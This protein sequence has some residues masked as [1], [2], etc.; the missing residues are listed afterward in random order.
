MG[1]VIGRL[2]GR[3][4]KE[5]KSVKLPGRL[6][7]KPRVAKALI[8]I[9]ESLGGEI[10]QDEDGAYVN[11]E[12]LRN[13]YSSLAN[14]ENVTV[15]D[16]T[17]YLTYNGKMWQVSKTNGL[18]SLFS[19][20]KQGSLEE[21][22]VNAM[23]NEDETMSIGTYRVDV[24]KLTAWDM[25]TGEM[26]D[27]VDAVGRGKYGRA[28]VVEA[29]RRLK[30]QGIENEDLSTL[31][32]Q[33]DN[34]DFTRE[35]AENA[36]RQGFSKETV[37][38]K[39]LET[40]RMSYDEETIR[41]MEGY[42]IRMMSKAI[43]NIVAELSESSD[44]EAR[45]AAMNR[46][47]A[48][49]KVGMARLRAEMLSLI[50]RSIE[51]MTTKDG[52]RNVVV[53]N[54]LSASRGFRNVWN[55]ELSIFSME[56]Y[57]WMK[58]N[59]AEN[60]EDMGMMDEKYRSS[61][62][63]EGEITQAKLDDARSFWMTQWRMQ[64]EDIKR[65]IE[66]LLY[67]SSEFVAKAEGME[68]KFDW[69]GDEA[70]RG[71]ANKED[72]EN[73]DDD[74]RVNRENWQ[75]NDREES[76]LDNVS[77][78]TY[79][80]LMDCKELD[81][82]YNDGR[83]KLDS[84]GEEKHVNVMQALNR[85][86]EMIEGCNTGEE[87]YETLKRNS[88]DP[89]V[90]D[91]IA[92]L[93]SS[94]E[95]A[96]AVQYD[97]KGNVKYD[98]ESILF[99]QFFHDMTKV[100]DVLAQVYLQEA[101]WVNGKKSYMLNV[102]VHRTKES[103]NG[104]LEEWITNAK[105]GVRIGDWADLNEEEYNEVWQLLKDDLKKYTNEEISENKDDIWAAVKAYYGR[106]GLDLNP[107]NSY[108]LSLEG[109][110][111][112]KQIKKAL[113]GRAYPTVD[114]EAS[115]ERNRQELLKTIEALHITRPDI[116][117]RSVSVGNKH[118]QTRT[119][120]NFFGKLQKVLS[121]DPRRCIDFLMS[122]MTSDIMFDRE[123]ETEIWDAWHGNNIGT[124]TEAKGSFGLHHTPDNVPFRQ[125]N[126]NNQQTVDNTRYWQDKAK[127]STDIYS[128]AQ[129]G[130]FRNEY[131]QD[132]YEE[133]LVAIRD[134]RQMLYGMDTI[135][136][137]QGLNQSDYKEWSE[138]EYEEV[139]MV[140]AT[141]HEYM[142]NGLQRADFAYGTCG[143]YQRMTLPSDSPHNKYV[144]MRRQRSFTSVAVKMANILEQERIRRRMV[145]ERENLDPEF[146]IGSFD[147]PKK[148]DKWMYIPRLNTMKIDFS[149]LSD[150]FSKPMTLDEALDILDN[151]EE[152]SKE[153]YRLVMS[154]AAQAA[155]MEEF[156]VYQ[157][158]MA[159]DYGFDIEGMQGCNNGHQAKTSKGSLGHRPNTDDYAL[160]KKMGKLADNVDKV[161]KGDITLHV[162]GLNEIEEKLKQEGKEPSR[163]V[164][165]AM[166]KIRE[167]MTQVKKMRLANTSYWTYERSNGHPMMVLLTQ[168][169]NLLSD[170]MW[171]SQD[172]RLNKDNGE[173]VDAWRISAETWVDAVI[174]E[175]VW[176]GVFNKGHYGE[177]VLTLFANSMY[178][179]AQLIQLTQDDIAF[180][181]DMTDFQKR[182]KQTVAPG[183][184]FN[185]DSIYGRKYE[186][187][188]VFEDIEGDMAVT[189]YAE[190]ISA[191]LDQKVTKG[192]IS[193]EIARILK[194]KYLEGDFTM[195]DGQ[196][197]RSMESMRATLDMMGKWDKATDEAFRRLANGTWTIDD[198]MKPMLIQKYYS[199][200][201]Q[202]E[203]DEQGHT[204]R[205]GIQFK[206]GNAPMMA[207][208]QSLPGVMRQNDLIA[209]IQSWMENNCIDVVE[210]KS[211]Q[212][213][214][215]KQSAIK[216]S[217]Q[218]AN[219]WYESQGQNNAET[220]KFV[221]TE[222]ELK[223][224]A[225]TGRLMSGYGVRS[226]QARIV[227]AYLEQL[228]GLNYRG[229]RTDK[230]RKEIGND[231]NAEVAKNKY[232]IS[233]KYE[234]RS[235]QTPQHEHLS[236]IEVGMGI[237][238]MKLVVEDLGD[239]AVF[240]VRD[241]NGNEKT[242]SAKEVRDLYQRLLTSKTVD[243][244]VSLRNIMVDPKKLGEALRSSIKSNKRYGA[245]MVKSFDVDENSN[246]KVPLFEL[247]NMQNIQSLINSLSR[248]R[249]MKTKL[250]GGKCIQMCCFGVEDELGIVM[251][252]GN[253]EL[254]LDDAIA[255]VL[256]ENPKMTRKRAK[257]IA[258]KRLREEYKN[259]E[260]SIA[261]YECYMPCW[262]KDLLEA[263]IK[264]T[265]NGE[266]IV[267]MASIPTE[268]REMIGYRVPTEDK[269]S[270]FPLK[271]KGFLPQNSGSVC[272][273]PSEITLIT[274][275]DF[276]IDSVYI[277]MR[278]FDINWNKA[279]VDTVSLSGDF[280][281]YEKNKRGVAATA[282]NILQ[283][284]ESF[285][286]ILAE[287]MYAANV[288]IKKSGRHRRAAKGLI[289]DVLGDAIKEGEEETIANEISKELDA[290]LIKKGLGEAKAG[291][292]MYMNPLVLHRYDYRAEV[293]TQDRKSRNNAIVDIAWSVLTN[294]DTT[295]K[296]LNP[297]GFDVMKKCQLILNAVRVGAAINY[298]QFRTMSFEEAKKWL[299]QQNADVLSRL[300]TAKC[301]LNP[302][303][304]TYYFGQNKVGGT[305]TAIAASN[306]SAHALLQGLGV[307]FNSKSYEISVNSKKL[308]EVDGTRIKSD[309]LTTDGLEYISKIIGTW[310]AAAVD[311]AKE[312]TSKTLNFTEK[313][314]KVVALMLRSGWNIEE[315]CIFVT[316]PII[317]E[318]I[319]RIS[320]NQYI[321]ETAIMRQLA[322]ETKKKASEEVAV[323][324]NNGRNESKEKKLFNRMEYDGWA[325]VT[326]DDML[327]QYDGKASAVV[328]LAVLT[329]YRRLSEVGRDLMTASSVHRTDKA[330]GKDI[331]DIL[332]YEDKMKKLYRKTFRLNVPS[333]AKLSSE[334]D[335]ELVDELMI[336]SNEY[337]VTGH[338]NRTGDREFFVIDKHSL[339]DSYQEA[340]EKSNEQD[341][342]EAS[343]E[344]MTEEDVVSNRDLE[345]E[346]ASFNDLDIESQKQYALETDKRVVQNEEGQQ[347]IY[348]EGKG[349]YVLDGIYDVDVNK[350][351]KEA[352]NKVLAPLNNVDELGRPLALPSVR[353][354]YYLGVRG[355]ELMYAQYMPFM[356][357]EFQ[358]V[359]DRVSKLTSVRTMDA[360]VKRQ[361]MREYVLFKLLR[362]LEL[363]GGFSSLSEARD[364]FFN[365][366][367]REHFFNLKER[368]WFKSNEFLK[369]L[370]WTSD[371]KENA[372]K[373]Y[374]KS[375]LVFSDQ[376][377]YSKEKKIDIETAFLKLYRSR[378]IEQRDL[379]VKLFQYS[380]LRN[381][382]QYSDGFSNFIPQT[383][384]LEVPGYVQALNR[385]MDEAKNDEVN[386][387]L[388][389]RFI[390]QFILNH[391]YD[392]RGIG[393]KME[394]DGS[395][396][397]SVVTVDMSN[398]FES[399]NIPW[400]GMAVSGVVK[401]NPKTGTQGEVRF[402]PVI[403]TNNPFSSSSKN[404]FYV[405]DS[406]D[407]FKATYVQTPALGFDGNA[408]LEYDPNNELLES[409]INGKVVD[410]NDSIK[411]TDSEKKALTNL[412][413]Q[414][415]GLME[416]STSEVSKKIADVINM[417]VEQKII[418]STRKTILTKVLTAMKKSVDDAKARAQERNEESDDEIELNDTKSQEVLAEDYLK[419][420][421]D[422]QKRDE[423][424]KASKKEGP[425]DNESP[426]NSEG[427]DNNEGPTEAED[428]AYAAWIKSIEQSA[429]EDMEFS[430]QTEEDEQIAKYLTELEEDAKRALTVQQLRGEKI[431]IEQMEDGETDT[432]MCK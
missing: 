128:G 106:T 149:L 167:L 278:D 3:M 95:K 139:A 223:K 368:P 79:R 103:T 111:F 59:W 249:V 266:L 104:I 41:D 311:N 17:T 152:V 365:G 1:C 344:D 316:Q 115:N 290:F 190:A 30:A 269:Y 27:L 313:T 243:G 325:D 250:R 105:N 65:H 50:D 262:S 351:R 141:Y 392:M 218:E 234:D 299:E 160:R 276:D 191:A 126:E 58:D 431:D 102:K 413:M 289:K 12:E 408:Y 275:S 2:S 77:T 21:K 317:M 235:V 397:G 60:D 177:D 333:P 120:P 373:R 322:E 229:Q 378:D 131:I 97:D 301:P 183:Q 210:F 399:N 284:S 147:N 406:I 360:D 211:C 329:T 163:E 124:I 165:S 32:S 272:I 293:S 356:S 242:M 171:S 81:T 94:Y 287:L 220:R 144:R 76:A 43:D 66:A 113:S 359:L 61:F 193:D 127:S 244:F 418:Q 207:L 422:K 199:Y 283:N 314:S 45:K 78:R 14:K 107:A 148:T 336:G 158:T 49:A 222:E 380:I 54:N 28:L 73:R 256:E 80:L 274:G 109:N 39:E 184:Q 383:L 421:R 46:H 315:T 334:R 176:T 136:V 182:N 185:T 55:E 189:P 430:R 63:I 9:Y 70:K 119:K 226:R 379:A 279:K 101:G 219:A 86:V 261:Y 117:E 395:F 129:K 362:N 10:T 291:R 363:T 394:N 417:M 341:E 348:V 140:M 74:G 186:R 214:G 26:I 64:R 5:I 239:D 357:R 135:D 414:E 31:A 326:C 68:L 424:K 240:S 201:T 123:G 7:M 195:T 248:K 332:A 11:P 90:K 264:P 13:L 164:Q 389:T 145:R 255:S 353:S 92:K 138:A 116:R 35:F 338:S 44:P 294:S 83:Y 425:D 51:S 202:L 179:T 281:A 205:R 108:W 354:Q 23:R 245:E 99:T 419:K 400:G 204:I 206:D 96:K 396:I 170:D 384:K 407:G 88:R 133:A 112:S 67:D 197:L 410:D 37:L 188:V 161:E 385:I 345:E 38:A 181:K 237:Q 259:G 267:D 93:L 369:R 22:I 4:I 118:L 53:E 252:N 409:V 328:Q 371:K 282:V 98:D 300:P 225:K 91:A 292:N 346:T 324:S 277:I 429:T 69:N 230:E 241:A 154:V 337:V 308:R 198:L 236:D 62:G 125:L 155:M 321:K 402:Y 169:E 42:S 340:V 412:L 82:Y 416:G 196:A 401:P 114:M 233:H 415:E 366:E 48:V 404:I 231:E 203:T 36:R 143:Y 319:K 172:V 323:S 56:F 208:L 110:E 174:D 420:L 228:T 428:A 24:S 295:A 71:N 142:A 387:A 352:L 297:G 257:E 146:K 393:R 330:T 307:H 232:I 134:G 367:F 25:N 166:Q 285:G 288:P 156:K 52:S 151:T 57:N 432:K 377:G 173:L 15:I 162:K 342:K 273:M 221:E 194:K 403:R 370:F 132:L 411:L 349:F 305:M 224:D 121:T 72:D 130:R 358:E 375:T 40:L 381:G 361:I 33:V 16:G 426:D 175:Q 200:N 159:E 327:T 253:K 271:I 386:D 331:F 137:V 388:V 87:A 85:L 343:E 302:A 247:A 372:T 427:P 405:L 355:L 157:A 298:E 318:L 100:R 215:T 312:P 18:Y 335:S 350:E 20:V 254:N 390:S 47:D 280:I 376:G 89:F 227:Q 84:L 34:E 213:I 217:L 320:Q 238:L 6:I 192:E 75:M 374:P 153:D 178:N 150:M 187:I 304:Y 286:G 251:K 180:N 268:L 398:I 423:M 270:M 339:D 8:G 309:G 122:E 246:F 263:F 216:V 209:G 347:G 303:T 265:E 168:I 19:A 296:M 391:C 258:L 260:L 212:K 310:V 382:A 364:Y 306:A 29:D